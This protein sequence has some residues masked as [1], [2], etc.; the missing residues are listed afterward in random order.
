[1]PSICVGAG[2]FHWES[3][4]IAKLDPTCP[5]PWWGSSAKNPARLVSQDEARSLPA[6]L[7]PHDSEGASVEAT[8]DEKVMNFGRALVHARVVARPRCFP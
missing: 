2:K 3:L 1:M 4:R 5:C 7:L 6:L 8:I